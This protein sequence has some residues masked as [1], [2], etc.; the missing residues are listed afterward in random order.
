MRLALI[1]SLGI[2]PYALLAQGPAQA[3]QGATLAPAT[4]PK[5]PRPLSWADQVLQQESYA[6]PPPEL[7]SAVLAP[8]H[9]NV[10]LGNL[11]PDKKWFLREVSDGPVVMA[12][13]SRPFDE[14]GG[15][16]LDASA[17]RTRALTYR[18]NVAIEL[19]SPADGSRKTLPLPAGTRVTGATWSPDGTAIAYYVHG[20]DA[21]HIWLADVAT[22]KSR[23]ITKTPVLA[24]LVTGIEFTNGGKQIA[25]VLVPDGR[26]PRPAQPMAPGGPEVN[27]AEDGDK[28]RLRT[29]P[30][31]MRTPYEFE[32]LEWHATGQYALIDVATQAVKKI[33]SPA[34]IRSI[35]PSPDG[36]F[37]R[38]TV[39]T[40]PFSYIVP[41]SSF[42]QKEEVW[43]STGK[44]LVELSSR[45]IN[46]GVQ[47]ATA[48][49]Q[50]AP[51]GGGGRGGG[52]NQ[53]GK[54]ELAWR[55]DGQGFTYLEQDPPPPSATAS[56]RG[57]ATGSGDQPAPG[58]A[59]T[60]GG[61]G[62]GAGRQGGNAAPRP[63][64][65]YQWLAPFTDATKKVLYESPTRMT[66]HRFSE[67]MQMLFY[68]E[69]ANQQTLDYAIDLAAPADKHVLVRYRTDDFYA[70]PGTLMGA[71]GA[72]GGGGGGGRGG[73]GGG[74]AVLLSA[75]KA[76]VFYSGTVYDKAPDK[77]GPK[78]FIDQVA[79]KTGEKQRIFESNNTDTFER[80]SSVL[81]INAK[82]FVL[83][84]EGPTKQPQQYLVEN[85][86]RKQL[87][88]NEDMHPD[89]TN[90]P[91]ERFVVERPD[92]FKFRVVVNLPPGYQKGTRLPAL[93]WFYPAEF[94]TQEAYDSPDRS[95]NKNQFQNFGAR[96][97]EYFVRLGYAVVEPDTPIVGPEGMM[98]NN[99][100]ND[101]RNDL[102]ATIDE[103]DRRALVDRT[104][105]AIGGHSYG[106]FSTVNAMVNTPFFK[107]GIAGDGA[108]NR[109]LTP[110]GFQTERR[111]LWTAPNVYLSMSP[112]L[113]ANNLT[114]ALLMY[115]GMHDQN[116]GTDPDNSIRLF[117]AL[118]GLGKTTALYMYPLEDHGPITQ[119]TLLDLWA[120]WG[121][122]LD[123]Y[124]KNPQ[125]PDN[126]KPAPAAG[127]GGRR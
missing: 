46:L 121:A 122:W 3:P 16:F 47:P 103:L 57:G 27:L 5:A 93:F 44:S 34:M 25:A 33:G 118:N 107:A 37:A 113:S 115:H 112:F 81:D 15:L 19:I 71:G 114:G 31:L 74:G 23:Q 10:T 105:L 62:R 49:P 43:D 96:S 79:I 24:T 29:F 6:T 98:N 38:V 116:V 90:A 82:R 56:A 75:D 55:P 70:N 108:Y 14:L 32:L 45:P 54:R 94:T 20:T 4:P 8:R 12:K 50:A 91:R 22:L 36:Q 1:L 86:N 17:N 123:K 97:M 95:F 72:G 40:K 9:L 100:V 7:A 99:Y 124:V 67:D 69:T 106:A 65:V 35:D 119:E 80:V 120:R 77:V 111:D 68:R 13:F 102:S 61:G 41:V 66:G 76:S 88:N 64:R 84:V 89:L 48:D 92:G 21:T 63:D 87:T 52:A 85:G 59:A 18:T 60:G 39:M 110:L 73:G 58:V 117:H 11:S 26:R 30:S 53:A 51:A 104:R 127:G 101:L 2:T 78:T 83:T 42:G 109:T 126:N 125:K 28:N